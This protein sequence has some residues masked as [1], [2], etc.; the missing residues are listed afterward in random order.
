M[1]GG[2]QRPGNAAPLA[3]AVSRTIG[4]T[5]T[6]AKD[7]SIA[8]RFT[9]AQA[10]RVFKDAMRDPGP[11]TSRVAAFVMRDSPACVELSASLA[12]EARRARPGAARL[13]AALLQQGVADGVRV[14]ASDPLPQIQARAHEAVR[15]VVDGLPADSPLKRNQSIEALARTLEVP[16][17]RARAALD[18]TDATLLAL[19]LDTSDDPPDATAL[20]ELLL[21]PLDAFARRCVAE[22]LVRL[23]STVAEA[24]V[25]EVDRRSPTPTP[26]LLRVLRSLRHGGAVS[27]LTRIIRRPSTFGELDAVPVL[28]AIPGREPLILLLD[29]LADDDE[30]IAA[31]ASN[32]LR[33]RRDGDIAF[34]LETF[35]QRVALRA[36]WSALLA[37][38]AGT[39]SL[40]LLVE[41]LADGR[42]GVHMGAM[43]GLRALGREAIPALLPTLAASDPRVLASALTLVAE[44][45]DDRAT[46]HVVH[47][48]ESEAADVP[49]A[50]ARALATLSAEAAVTAGKRLVSTGP[51]EL[52]R[53]LLEAIGDQ[54]NGH[55]ASVLGSALD[56][57]DAAIR[58]AAGTAVIA[59]LVHEM[60]MREQVARVL[61]ANVHT[62]AG[63]ARFAECVAEAEER[64]TARREAAEAARRDFRAARMT[65]D[66]VEDPPP[67]TRPPRPLAD[68][69]W[70]AVTA[71]PAAEPGATL[72]VDVW[73]F[74]G[75]KYQEVLDRA[76]LAR[77]GRPLLHRATGPVNLKPDA[78]MSVVLR[79]PELGTAPMVE[80]LWWT[81][82]IA[83]CSFALM[84]PADARSATY[85][86]R[87]DVHVG[88]LRIAT[89]LF[90]VEVAAVRD[91]RPIDVTTAT[92]RLRTAFASYASDDRDLVL[93][94]IQ[95]MRSVVPDLDVFLDVM[96]LRAGD[97]WRE[98]LQA[99]ICSRD[100]FYLFWSL[101]A[102]RSEW[103]TREWQLAL[104]C[105]GLD[106]ISPVPLVSAHL[107]PPPSELAPLHFND[108]TL[109]VQAPSA[110]NVPRHSPVTGWVR[111]LWKRPRP[112]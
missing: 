12:D 4:A 22:A 97:R 96:S 46:A 37:A 111:R 101:A 85:L 102:S 59:L 57:D 44:A 45:R 19:W 76:R 53:V 10:H 6:P 35:R 29:L 7:A 69:V 55:L 95:G 34:I 73:S 75:G 84:V 71:P 40:P 68:S 56:T 70:F 38:L 51:L 11:R 25:S 49:Q 28:A 64:L 60:A 26:E 50:A 79:L 30:Q 24:V 15:L 20:I 83:N 27:Y 61:A 52:A 108:W 107:V 98:R 63:R 93:G 1:G 72:V 92:T 65:C 43:D 47:L 13:A 109:A 31:S 81:G 103:V 9:A 8:M 2:H 16:G 91:P 99:E 88:S 23:G 42:R 33:E 105:R 89:L 3:A 77:G 74:A 80:T 5:R 100:V 14:L 82:E 67:V 87:A 54:G 106:H 104:G 41:A 78:E 94:R 39:A 17:A 48:L 112:E 90:E 66:D 110:R 32:A 18:G 86:G 36:R 21:D 62:D 58:D